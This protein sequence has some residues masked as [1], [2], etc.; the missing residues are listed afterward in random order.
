MN[1]PFAFNKF[2]NQFKELR[3]GEEEKKIRDNSQ[4]V[5][6][7]E[8][9]QGGYSY[10]GNGS[11]VVSTALQSGYNSTGYNNINIQFEEYFYSKSQRISKYKLMSLYPV[12]NNTLDIISDEAI[13]DDIDGD[14]IKIEF[15][16]EVPSYVKE[17]IEDLFRYLIEDVFN[18]NENCWDLF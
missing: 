7:T 4:G 2:F 17:K 11:N 8:V 18:A 15:K 9:A 14:I 10:S 5:S 13:V 3:V 12:I 6:Q 16:E 1:F